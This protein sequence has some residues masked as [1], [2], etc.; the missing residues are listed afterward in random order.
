MSIIK[1]DDP[2]SIQ[3]SHLNSR[4]FRPDCL[5]RSKNFVDVADVLANYQMVYLEIGAGKGRHALQF[6]NRNPSAYLIAVERTTV[7][8]AAFQKALTIEQLPN[9]TAIHT[10]AIAW[11]VYALPPDCLSA[12]YILYPN[13]EPHNKNQ[14][15]A[16]MPFFEFLLS[17]LKDGGRIYIA[18]NVLG[19][20]DEAQKQVRNVW[21][22]PCSLKTVEKTSARTAFEI[23]YLARG[24][25]CAE[26]QILKPVGYRTCFDETDLTD[27]SQKTL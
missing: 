25:I 4:V 9:V 15:W 5:R 1:N 20:I 17:R 14:R 18:S 13:P 27:D 7:K 12:I 8:F 21:R 16:N 23:K 24:E 22:L 2:F 26:L 3:L 6:A 10:D 19:Y 11:T